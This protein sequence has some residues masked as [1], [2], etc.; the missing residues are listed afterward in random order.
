MAAVLSAVSHFRLSP[1]ARGRCSAPAAAWSAT[2]RRC[3]SGGARR[4]R[5]GSR[6]SANA[7]SIMA[8]TDPGANAIITSATATTAGRK[9]AAKTAEIATATAN[10]PKAAPTKSSSSRSERVGE[11]RTGNRADRDHRRVRD[12]PRHHRMD[13]PGAVQRRRGEHGAEQQPARKAHAIGDDRA[14]GRGREQDGQF[15]EP[16]RLDGPVIL[17]R[18]HGRQGRAATGRPEGR[19]QSRQRGCFARSR[20]PEGRPRA[21]RRAPELATCR[22]A[23]PRGRPIDRPPPVHKA[24]IPCAADGNDRHRDNQHDDTERIGRHSVQRLRRH[25]GAK[26]GAD[27]HEDRPHQQC[28]DQHWPAGDRR[29]GHGEDRA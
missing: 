27:Q 18:A 8:S 14:D 25:H 21:R 11:A 7:S 2:R 9:I 24:Q 13:K 28:R 15:V 10:E 1:F 26:R 23:R 22:R 20:S 4:H 5:P 17:R 16:S 6:C 19:R 3:A 12:P 29:S